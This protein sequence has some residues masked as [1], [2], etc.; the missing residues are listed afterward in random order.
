MAE[1]HI[2][3][4]D[5]STTIVTTSYAPFGEKVEG[6]PPARP[7]DPSKW[8]VAFWTRE[9]ICSELG[10]TDSQ[11]GV[12]RTLGFPEARESTTTGWW[13]KRIVAWKAE[14]VLD[15]AERVRSLGLLKK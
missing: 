12:A 6:G 8:R 5:G 11:F 2:T 3:G 4:R 10:L 13:P 14:E 9:D 1:E 15:W 7:E